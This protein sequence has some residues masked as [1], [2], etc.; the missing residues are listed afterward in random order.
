MSHSKVF[1]VQTRQKLLFIKQVC[2]CCLCSQKGCG[3]GG[4]RLVSYFSSVWA[5]LQAFIPSP[6]ILSPTYEA[7]GWWGGVLQNPCRI[8][9]KSS[10]GARG[11]QTLNT[12]TKFKDH[13]LSF[14]YLLRYSGSLAPGVQHC[15]LCILMDK[16]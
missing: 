9:T 1:S 12:P 8:N 13:H 5:S 14:R 11:G 16:W 7:W 4:E 2:V 10:N 6:A 15:G 3:E